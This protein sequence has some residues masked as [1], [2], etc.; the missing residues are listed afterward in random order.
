MNGAK[1]EGIQ[2]IAGMTCFEALPGAAEQKG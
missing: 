2:A 1:K